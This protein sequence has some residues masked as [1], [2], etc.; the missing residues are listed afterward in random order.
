MK[1]KIINL[2]KLLI[3]LLEDNT[4]LNKFNIHNKILKYNLNSMLKFN[5]LKLYYH[6]NYKVNL[7]GIKTNYSK[8]DYLLYVD[9]FN[10]KIIKDLPKNK[11]IDLDNLELEFY[12]CELTNNKLD[13]LKVYLK[14][15]DLN[16]NINNNIIIK[17][18]KDESFLKLINDL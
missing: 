8:F 5:E 16:K 2:T 13:G 11:T 12:K 7:N 3:S 17:D 14:P 10:Y 6:N 1:N 4:D 15:V 9:N 18:E